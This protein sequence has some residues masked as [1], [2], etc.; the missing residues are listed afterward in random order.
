MPV[1]APGVMFAGEKAQLRFAGRE[2]HESEMLLLYEPDCG[3][4]EIVIFAD[5]PTAID[6]AV[7]DALKV[8]FAPPP[9]ELHAGA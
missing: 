2:S 9:E 5:V 4:A 3:V 7:G 1:P 8:R 6:T